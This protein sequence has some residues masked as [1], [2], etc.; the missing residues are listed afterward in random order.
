MFLPSSF[1]HVLSWNDRQGWWECK[2]VVGN[3]P[4]PWLDLVWLLRLNVDRA[5]LTGYIFH[6]PVRSWLRSKFLLRCAS[7]FFSTARKSNQKVPPRDCAACGSLKIDMICKARPNSL[8]LNAPQMTSLSFD[9]TN[10]TN[11]QHTI[12]EVAIKTVT[13]RLLLLSQCVLLEAKS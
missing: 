3:N 9:L 4:C 10:Q 1:Q 7:H 13:L 6:T 12:R 5:Y 2:R 8:L 11:F